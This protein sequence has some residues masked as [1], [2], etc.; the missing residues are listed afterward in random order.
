V[1]DYRR[2]AR[3]GLHLLSDR[4]V[5]PAFGRHDKIELTMQG[6]VT[7]PDDES[8][9]ILAE[10]QHTLPS[11]WRNVFC[12]PRGRGRS[13]ILQRVGNGW[14]FSGK[15]RYMQT[16]QPNRRQVSLTLSIN[17]T[18]FAA[19]VHRFNPQSVQAL[20]EIAPH[21][22]LRIEPQ[23]Q[24]ALEAAALTNW[25]NYLPGTD[26]WITQVTQQ[27]DELVILYVGAITRLI[28]EDFDL[29][30]EAA[31]PLGMERPLLTLRPPTEQVPQLHHAEAYWEFQVD[32][33][34]LSFAALERALRAAA[35]NFEVT[36]NYTLREGRDASAKW[37][38]LDYPSGIT[39][40]AYSKLSTRLRI[41]VTY[42]GRTRSIGDLVY[43]E[44]RFCEG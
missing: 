37:I 10:T 26:R 41:E 27:W 42:R 7:S 19:H 39:L 40:K 6:I 12:A 9:E 5:N 25:D 21:E 16:A 24:S 43:P 4:Q 2:R 38:T 30:S 8:L 29:R 23:Q 36:E 15:V 1:P 18:R 28:V 14:L 22:L 44:F 32:D 35:P 34:R 3:S 31:Y 20:Q 13:S 17:P 33:A 11:P